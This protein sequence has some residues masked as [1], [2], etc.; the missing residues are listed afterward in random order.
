MYIS[1]ICDECNTIKK[2][3]SKYTEVEIDE[4]LANH[5]EWHIEIIPIK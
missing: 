3:C 4:I 5:P 1:V 2:Y